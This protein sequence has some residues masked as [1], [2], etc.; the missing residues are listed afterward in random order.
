MNGTYSRVWSLPGAVGSQPWS[1]VKITWSPGRISDS[2]RGMNASSAL[3]SICVAA[4]V[5]TVAVLRIEVVQVREDEAAVYALHQIER[6]FHRII[7]IGHAYRRSDS[8]P[9]ID[10][11][12]FSH[13]MHPDPGSSE[14]VEHALRRLDRIIASIRRSH[15]GPRL[16]DKRPRD[17]AVHVVRLDQHRPRS[18]APIIQDGQ[19]ND[20]FVGGDLKDRIGRGVENRPAGGDVLAP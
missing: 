15:E 2:S 5:P 19:R 6:L 4:N 18:L 10:V 11:A 8:V 14:P 7:V 9:A 13:G 16:A 1:A 17:H 3:E 12:N 20:L